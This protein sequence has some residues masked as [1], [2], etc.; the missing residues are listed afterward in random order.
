MVAK[1]TGQEKWGDGGPGARR[2]VQGG[3]SVF[4]FFGAF[5]FQSIKKGRQFKMIFQESTRQK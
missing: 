4:I 1:G 3:F 5:L 2:G